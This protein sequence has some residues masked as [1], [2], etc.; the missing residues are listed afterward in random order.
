MRVE[1]IHLDSA[2]EQ[3]MYLLDD[4]TFNA[5]SLFDYFAGMIGYILDGDHGKK[6][7]WKKVYS[8]CSD[9][10]NEKTKFSKSLN[11]MPHLKKCVI[12][13][14]REVVKK[15]CDYRADIYHNKKDFA[16]GESSISDFNPKNANIII[17]IPK[18]MA[19]Q[20]GI[21]ENWDITDA[22]IW[23]ASTACSAMNEVLESMRH[24]IYVKNQ[25]HFKKIYPPSHPIW[26]MKFIE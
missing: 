12:K 7:D 17:K 15:L 13:V 16:P 3:A 8:T 21:D 25:E 26:T 22:A 14:Q 11:G 5:I 6:A 4:I 9:S 24:D 18:R 20:L 1:R 23:L 2:M 10:N 19:S